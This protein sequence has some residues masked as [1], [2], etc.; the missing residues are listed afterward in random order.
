MLNKRFLRW[1]GLE[2]VQERAARS[3]H[4]VEIRDLIRLL[5]PV[6]INRD[7]VRIGGQADGG[8]LVPDDLDGLQVVVSPGVANEISF[9]LDLAARGIDVLMA[10][11]SVAGPPVDH[12]RFHFQNKFLAVY[13]DERHVRLDSLCN[14]IALKPGNDRMLQMDIEGAE[15]EAILDASDDTLK[16]FRTMVIEFHYLDRLFNPFPFCLIKATFQ[17]LLR[18]HHVVHIH[19]NNYSKVK[20]VQEIEIPAVMEFTFYRKDRAMVLADRKLV[21]PHALDRDNVSYKPSLSLP[22]C[23]Q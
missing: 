15:Y 17:K 9:D 16:S 5:R 4:F 20:R 3:A 2:G 7:L 22:G 14:V 11:G 10:D 18:H 23:W 12:A 19:P 1:L 21:F 6:A 8:Y 13:D